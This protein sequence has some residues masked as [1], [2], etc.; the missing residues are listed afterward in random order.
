MSILLHHKIM[1]PLRNIRSRSHYFFPRHRIE[2]DHS[3][4]P[5]RLR[6]TRRKRGR[7]KRLRKCIKKLGG[8]GR[9]G[10]G[11]GEEEGGKARVLRRTPALRAGRPAQGESRVNPQQCEGRFEQLFFVKLCPKS[12]TICEDTPM[13][14]PSGPGREAP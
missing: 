7:L 12:P 10:G 9:G 5:I 11:G 8:E 6:R 13:Q 14:F 4:R 2:H 1:V 3:L